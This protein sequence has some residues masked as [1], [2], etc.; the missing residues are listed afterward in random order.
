MTKQKTVD[1]SPVLNEI[2]IEEVE[3]IIAPGIVL[4]D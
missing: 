1:E 3:E 2:E 4:T